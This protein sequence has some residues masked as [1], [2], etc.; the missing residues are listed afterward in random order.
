MPTKYTTNITVTLLKMQPPYLSGCNKRVRQVD[1]CNKITENSVSHEA[2][3]RRLAYKNT[4]IKT[5]ESFFDD[6]DMISTYYLIVVYDKI[7]NIPLLS[8]RYFYDQTLISKTVNNETVENLN[9]NQYKEGEL[10]LADRLSGNTE[11]PV[12]IRNRNYIFSL[13]Y[14]EILTKNRNS[15]LVL[16]ARKEPE[17]KLLKKY[18][19][20]GFQT[21][22]S[23]MHN[24]KDHWIVLMDL[25]K[26]Y[27]SG[28]KT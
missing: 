1:M 10:F 4:P 17:D 21:I 6:S 16:M 26:A 19:R 14:T 11:H 3:L 15:S 28:S 5:E 13:F 18:L 22:G 20:L 2:F 8:A 27:Y 24:E 7:Q 12:Y 23:I 25:K 9:T